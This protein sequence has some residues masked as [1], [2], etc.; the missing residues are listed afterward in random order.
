M[1][2]GPAILLSAGRCGRALLYPAMQESIRYLSGGMRKLKIRR[3]VEQGFAGFSILNWAELIAEDI[4][5]V[6]CLRYASQAA[7]RHAL[8]P[9]DHPIRLSREDFFP[10]VP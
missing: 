8:L 2:T 9:V 10:T 7:L 6:P 1:R 5:G 4:A 3:G